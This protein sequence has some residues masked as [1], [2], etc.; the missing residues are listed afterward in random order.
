M[1]TSRARP[2]LASQAE[3][4]SSIIG[5]EEN[6]VVPIW[7]DH[8]AMAR[9]KDNIMASKHRRADNRCFRWKARPEKPRVNAKVKLKC[10][11]VIRRS[12]N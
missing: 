11:G 8:R 4:A 5:A 2:A 6:V 7:Y 12:W 10:T 1:A 9:Y 3:N